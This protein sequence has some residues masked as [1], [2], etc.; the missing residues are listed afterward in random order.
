[1]WNARRIFN[2][3][4][5]IVSQFQKCAICCN[6]F[7]QMA[8]FQIDRVAETVALLVAGAHLCAFN[9]RF[10]IVAAIAQSFVYDSS[11][12]DYWTAKPVFNAEDRG[13]C[14]CLRLWRCCRRGCRGSVTKQ[15]SCESVVAY[16][17]IEIIFFDELVYNVGIVIILHSYNEPDIAASSSN[18]QDSIVREASFGHNLCDCSSFYL[19]KVSTIAVGVKNNLNVCGVDC[20]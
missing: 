10:D 13:S 12:I 4:F 8:S 7:E 19:T 2:I 3:V 1:M 5:V 14:W 16:H 20:C 18:L 11:S 6:G 15:H 9:C 17:N